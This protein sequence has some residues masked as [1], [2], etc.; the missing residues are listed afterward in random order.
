MDQS[1]SNQS[2]QN[3]YE[4][5]QNNHE[6]DYNYE[7]DQSYQY[8]YKSDQSNQ[9]LTLSNKN[10]KLKTVMKSKPAFK[11]SWLNE[12]RWLQFNKISQQMFCKYCKCYNKSN[13]FRSTRSVNFGRKSSVKEHASLEQ[14]K[15]AIK[16]DAAKKTINKELEQLT[17]QNKNHI[18]RIAKILLQSYNIIDKLVTFASDV[19]SVMIGYKNGVVQKL[20]Q[21]CLYIVYNHCIAHHL[22]LACKDSQK[23]IDYFNNIETIIRN[24]YKYY[25]NSAK[26]VHILQEYQQILN[27]PKLCLKKLKDI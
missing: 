22:A 18:I 12:F 16:L 14:H 9:K 20:L 19:V 1:E 3:H 7:N 23:Q 24:I 4:Y 21:I 11:N 26:R 17:E 5:I 8:N 10:K 15:N 25:K 6:S 27:C 2:N 13:V